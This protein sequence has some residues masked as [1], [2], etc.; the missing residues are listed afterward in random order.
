MIAVL[1]ALILVTLAGCALTRPIDRE[2]R[3]AAFFGSA[4]FIGCGYAALIM[5][6]LTVV[7]VEWS[8][9]VVMICL[10]AP[11]ALLALDR[12]RGQARLPVL[13]PIDALVILLVLGHAVFATWAPMYEWDWFGI[14]GLKGRVFFDARGIDW[15]FVQT[16]ISHPDYPPLVPLLVDLPSVLR[17]GWEDRWVGLIFTALCA[18]FLLIVR[19]TLREEFDSDL[20]AAIGTLAIA[21]PALNLWV[22]LAEGPVMAFGCAGLLLV[23]RG[24]ARPSNASLHLGAILLGLSAWCKNEGI[25]LIGVTVIAALIVSARRV[26]RLWPAA[27]IAGVWMVTRSVYRLHTDFLQGDVFDRVLFHLKQFG[28]VLHALIIYAPDLRLFWIAA[29]LT[30]ILF[31]RQAWMRERFLT[32][33]V[34]LQS[35]L[36]AGQ[37]LATAA[38]IRAHI[39]FAW[40]RLPHQIGPALGY[41]CVVLLIPL[42]REARSEPDRRPGRFD[43]P[44]RTPSP[45]APT[46]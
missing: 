38:D 15:R 35:S 20:L 7:H 6:F 40:N 27:A 5:F 23:R 30:L 42:I 17:R 22:G 3:G 45:T 8:R 36:L 4:I 24:L 9:T 10:L 41:L 19:G 12:Q 11:I 18:A 43:L 14:W 13:H 16:N 1:A 26:W 39:E 34:L 44:A 32:I 33:A 25:A 21:S 2:L 29:F 46:T 31:A 37:A 28:D